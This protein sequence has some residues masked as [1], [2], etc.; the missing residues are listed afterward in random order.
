MGTV[1]AF[2][3]CWRESRRHVFF[4]RILVSFCLVWFLLMFVRG[5][6]EKKLALSLVSVLLLVLSLAVQMRLEKETT[7]LCEDLQGEYER[8]MVN[9]YNGALRR[10]L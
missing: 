4:L 10:E 7:E 1:L 9:V 5:L 8:T 3:R 6:V 2:Y